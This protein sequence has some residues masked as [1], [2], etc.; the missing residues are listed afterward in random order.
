[1]S[2]RLHVPNPS[3]LWEVAALFSMNPEPKSVR[4]RAFSWWWVC[5]RHWKTDVRCSSIRR[6]SVIH[7]LRVLTMIPIS[8]SMENKESKW[9]SKLSIKHC[10]AWLEPLVF[11]L[12]AVISSVLLAESSASVVSSNLTYLNSLP[13]NRAQ[14]SNRKSYFHP[15]WVI[16]GTLFPP[17]QLANTF[18]AK[19]KNMN[20]M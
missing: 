17:A 11:K 16:I 1:M 3:I 6:I 2:T 13:Q 4:P 9:D 20:Y 7:K 18:T 15:S 14:S 8:L 19:K 10:G 12:A 5:L